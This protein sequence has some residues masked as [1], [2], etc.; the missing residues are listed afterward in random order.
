[1]RYRLA[2]CMA[3]RTYANSSSSSTKAHT[4]SDWVVHWIMRVSLS[5]HGLNLAEVSLLGFQLVWWPYFSIELISKHWVRYIEQMADF[6]NHRTF[7]WFKPS[8]IW[9]VKK[10]IE[11]TNN[12]FIPIEHLV[13]CRAGKLQDPSSTIYSIKWR[14]FTVVWDAAMTRLKNPFLGY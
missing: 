8:N 13:P 1:M 14:Q 7:N 3:C 5:Q 10:I 12:F 9:L 6:A 11:Q 2:I 4:T